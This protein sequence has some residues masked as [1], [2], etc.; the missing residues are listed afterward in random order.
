MTKKEKLELI[1]QLKERIPE[2]ERK[3]EEARQRLEKDLYASEKEKNVLRNWAYEGFP[4]GDVVSSMEEYLEEIDLEK[5][6]CPD[7]GGKVVSFY[8]RSPQWTWDGLMGRA[9]H[10]KICVDCGMQFDFGFTGL[11]VMN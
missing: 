3:E 2:F 4:Y 1:R 10:M 11:I 6:C 8:F 9:G 7:C 5:E